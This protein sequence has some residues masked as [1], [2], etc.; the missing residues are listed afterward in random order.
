MY[1]NSQPSH[2]IFDLKTGTTNLLSCCLI[3]FQLASA[4]PPGPFKLNVH[5]TMIHSYENTNI[6]KLGNI[7]NMVVQ[8]MTD[9]ILVIRLEAYRDNKPPVGYRTPKMSCFR[10]N[11]T[12][13]KCLEGSHMSLLVRLPC[14]KLYLQS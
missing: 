12:V 14:T 9:I 6:L 3:Y 5:N 4:C 1:L 8:Q 11:W 10:A 13:Q 7:G 2:R